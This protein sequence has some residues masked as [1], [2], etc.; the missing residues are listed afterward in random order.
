MVIDEFSLK[1]LN[2]FFHEQLNPSQWLCDSKFF[3]PTRLILSKSRRIISDDH[4]K[5][6]FRNIKKLLI[7][8]AFSSDEDGDFISKFNTIFYIFL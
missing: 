3:N 7:F 1:E 5:F 4:F 8:K 6:V 2:L